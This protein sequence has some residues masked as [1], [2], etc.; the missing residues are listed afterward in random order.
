MTIDPE[1]FETQGKPTREQAR[2]VWGSL[3]NPS[4]RKVA[5][6]LQKRG[7]DAK[8]RT[9]ARWKALNWREDTPPL[10]GVKPSIRNEVRKEM[11]N[12]TAETVAQIAIVRTDEE[13]IAEEIER[14]LLMS[15]GE[16]DVLEAKARKI[17][18]IVLARQAARR[19]HVM[20]LIPK[21]TG[22]LVESMTGAA[23]VM[24]TGNDGQPPHASDPRVINGSAGHV[25]SDPLSSAIDKF[26]AEET[27]A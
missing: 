27:A 19:A 22:A 18:N 2:R 26:L 14:L 8:W 25:M 1:K 15:E 12:I 24:L 4:A 7:F 5:A 17:M 21:D 6:E 10:P 3:E 13:V 16:L 20:V 23:K 9:I 11:A